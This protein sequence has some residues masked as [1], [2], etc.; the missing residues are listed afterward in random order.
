MFTCYSHIFSYIH[1]Y[2]ICMCTHKQEVI[3]AICEKRLPL[4]KLRLKAIN[5]QFTLKGG[6]TVVSEQG[7]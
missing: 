3:L 7:V 2:Y 6:A 1:M 5:K 4:L